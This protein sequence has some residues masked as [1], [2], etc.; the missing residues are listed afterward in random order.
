METH[1]CRLHPQRRPLYCA[2]IH[3]IYFRHV[4]SVL[5]VIY[6]T[7]RLIADACTKSV[8]ARFDAM[9]WQSGAAAHVHHNIDVAG[10]GGAGARLLYQLL[11]VRGARILRSAV[12]LGRLH[13]RLHSRYFLSKAYFVYSYRIESRTITTRIL[14]QRLKWLT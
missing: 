2:S 9:C 13:H 6:L 12:R 3:R 7:L 14:F 11:N 4:S 5:I 10:R 8:G 1:A